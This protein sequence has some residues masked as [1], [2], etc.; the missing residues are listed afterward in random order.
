MSAMWSSVQGEGHRVLRAM[1]GVAFLV[2][3]SWSSWSDARAQKPALAQDSSFTPDERLRLR[4]GKSVKRKF[5]LDVADV[6][7]RAGLSYRLVKGTPIDVVSALRT[8]SGLARSIPY[9]LEATTLDERDGVARVRI[10]QGKPPIVGGYT[11]RMKWELNEYRARF[12]LDPNQAHDLRDIWGWFMAREVAPGLTLIC[13]A[14]AFDLGGV[15]EI[16]GSKVHR[17]SLSTADRIAELVE[18]R[19]GQILAGAAGAR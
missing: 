19:T 4:S 16:L 14:V 18:E 17:W 1:W 12:W 9:G 8:P 2:L 6:R 11:V 3:V 5:H 15:G 13:F 7:Y 10:K